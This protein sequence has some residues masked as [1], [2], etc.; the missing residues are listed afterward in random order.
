MFYRIPNKWVKEDSVVG[1]WG[2]Y[3]GLIN[4]YHNTKDFQDVL[5]EKKFLEIPLKKFPTIN[6]TYSAD[7]KLVLQEI[8][9]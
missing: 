2:S 3:L 8:E 7:D 9:R 4:W 5:T 6:F 1:F